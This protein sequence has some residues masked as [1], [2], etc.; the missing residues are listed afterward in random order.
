MNL[1]HTDKGPLEDK[2][3]RVEAI[4]DKGLIV[5]WG[6]SVTQ[7]LLVTKPYILYFKKYHYGFKKYHFKILK[8]LS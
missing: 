7:T 4:I 5:N 6:V 8:P 1:F 2:I 3:K